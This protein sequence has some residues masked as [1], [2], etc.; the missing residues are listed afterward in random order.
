MASRNIVAAFTFHISLAM[1]T[2]VKGASSF[3]N[4]MGRRGTRAIV[5]LFLIGLRSNG[6]FGML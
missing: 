5:D 1:P 4:G 2:R 6:H 3:S